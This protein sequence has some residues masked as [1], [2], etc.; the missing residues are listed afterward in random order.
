MNILMIIINSAVSIELTIP[1]FLDYEYGMCCMYQAHF[2]S[3]FISTH[4]PNDFK[5]TSLALKL[6]SKSSMQSYATVYTNRSW[7]YHLAPTLG[8]REL[9][10]Q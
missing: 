6:T 2:A 8:S 3:N 4:A 9:W 5:L 7:G 1:E 10:G